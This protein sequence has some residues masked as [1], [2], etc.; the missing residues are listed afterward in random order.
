V[1]LKGFKAA[2][3]EGHRFESSFTVQ[4]QKVTGEQLKNL[5]EYLEKSV[6]VCLEEKQISM[7]LE[8]PPELEEVEDEEDEVV[9]A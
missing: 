4:I 3:H 8:E 2:F 5:V 6:F 1:S 7:D 9:E